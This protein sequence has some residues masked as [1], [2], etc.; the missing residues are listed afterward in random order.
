MPARKSVLYLAKRIK[1]KLSRR[2]EM[3]QGQTSILTLFFRLFSLLPR[4]PCY[5]RRSTLHST[6]VLDFRHAKSHHIANLVIF[7]NTE[8]VT[9]LWKQF[10][11]GPS[12]EP[13]PNSAD[14]KALGEDFEICER[15]QA[16]CFRSGAIPRSRGDNQMGSSSVNGV[17]PF[18]SQART[19]SLK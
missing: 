6:M 10:S 11:K 2:T 15:N 3:P 14:R 16:V 7:G 18:S 5:P 12:R 1:R 17:D 19:Q 8:L 9:Q 13:I 4:Y